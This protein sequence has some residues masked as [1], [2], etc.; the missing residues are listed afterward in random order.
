MNAEDSFALV[1]YEQDWDF[2]YVRH[3][4]L[5]PIN[6]KEEIL[7]NFKLMDDECTNIHVKGLDEIR[8]LRAEWAALPKEKYMFNDQNFW[9]RIRYLKNE[10]RKQF[11]DKYCYNPIELNFVYKEQSEI[12][13]KE[14]D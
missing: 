10:V 12:L 7:F 3:V 11:I 14:D 8:E 2:T 5:F 6:R 1:L 9:K 4:W 13:P